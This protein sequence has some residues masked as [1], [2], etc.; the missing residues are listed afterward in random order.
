VVLLESIVI[1]SIERADQTGGARIGAISCWN[2]LIPD[3][4]GQL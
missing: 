2:C 3:F 1:H 4:I